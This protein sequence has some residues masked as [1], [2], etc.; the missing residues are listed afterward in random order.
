MD[1][2]PVPLRTSWS[3]VRCCSSRASIRTCVS[4]SARGREAEV[5]GAARA[6]RV[7]TELPAKLV[8]G[9]LALV[10]RTW[11][12]GYLLPAGAIRLRNGSAHARGA[13]PRRCRRLR[14]QRCSWGEARWPSCPVRTPRAEQYSAGVIRLNSRGIVDGP[15]RRGAAAGEARGNQTGQRGR[16]AQHPRLHERTNYADRVLRRPTAACK[17]PPMKADFFG[18]GA[19]A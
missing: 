11:K 14:G 5:L 12:F 3:S 13:N 19:S 1:S 7:A 4:A 16:R 6:R 2:W 17:K 10:K 8:L 15:S 18:R 9:L